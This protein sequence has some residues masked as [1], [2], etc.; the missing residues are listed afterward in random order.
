MRNALRLR[1]KTVRLVRIQ[2]VCNVGFTSRRGFHPRQELWYQ[3]ASLRLLFYFA[4]PPP[5]LFFFCFRNLLCILFYGMI[6][7]DVYVVH[8]N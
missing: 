5:P 8:T 1:K 2:L 3:S 4:F 6:S 7:F